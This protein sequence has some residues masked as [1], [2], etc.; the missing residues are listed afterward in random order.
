M[1]CSVLPYKLLC[2]FSE[3][4]EKTF[5]W[6]THCAIQKFKAEYPNLPLPVGTVSLQIGTKDLQNSHKMGDSIKFDLLIQVKFC[7]YILIL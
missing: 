1:S 6:L 2:S 3:F 7:F 4:E 5:Q